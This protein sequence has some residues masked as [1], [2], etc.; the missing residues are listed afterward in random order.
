MAKSRKISTLL[1]CSALSFG[2]FASAA[3]ASTYM[4][5]QSTKVP[6]EVASTEVDFSKNDLIQ[7]F[8]DLFPNQFDFLSSNDFQM[9]GGHMYPDDEKIRYHLY[10][11]KAVNGKQL[12]GSVGFV[13]DDLEIEHFSFQPLNEADAL[14]PAKVSKEEA[15]KIAIE[16]MSHIPTEEAYQLETD[17]QQYYPHRILT[18]PI[19]Y[20]FMFTRTKHQVP[21]ADQKMQVTVLGNGDVVEFYK[22]PVHKGAATFEDVAKV[23]DE[24][25]ILQKIKDNLS[26]DLYYSINMDYQTGKRTIELVYQPRT[27]NVHALTGQWQRANSYS[28]EPPKKTKIEKIVAE[29]LPPKQEGITKE[30]ARKLAEQLL[31]SKSDDVKLTIQ[32]VEEMKNHNGQEVFSIHYMYQVANGGYGTT[33]EINKHTGEIIQYADMSYQML[34]QAGKEAPKGKPVSEKEAL[35]SAIQHLKEWAPSY[36]HHY[37][38]PLDEAHVDEQSGVYYFSFP[39]VVNGIPVIGDQIS[40][41]INPDSSLNSFYVQYQEEAQWPA[42]DEIISEEEA[43][44][45]YEKAL[46][47]QLNYTK[48]AEAQH[49]DLVYVPVFNGQSFSTLDAKTGKWNSLTGE[50]NTI[51]VTH[52]WAEKELNY[53]LNAKILDVKDGET[54]NGDALATKG[55]ALKVIVNSLTYFYAD[56]YGEREDRSQTFDNINPDHPYYQVVEHAVG[57]GVIKQDTSFDVDAPITREELA[58]WYIRILG[59]EQAAKHSDI[60]KLDLQDA[61]QVQAGNRG[62]VALANSIG[63]LPAEKGHF[64]P[65][66]EVTYAELAVSIIRLA[67]EMSER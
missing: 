64:N 63:L 26:V 54:F 60:Y 20:S 6:I 14:F 66:Q 58:V 27:S 49:Y 67:H 17:I 52:P 1:T 43:R 8:R 38:Y 47:A 30:E 24:K 59:L 34:E 7:K 16:F 65:D 12:H 25:E 4:D 50:E 45:I 3:Q 37:A 51:V 55:E 28:T 35:A 62:Y 41:S 40:V 39:R 53:L 61:D 48:K 56:W 31:E 11:S 44:A 57:M 23:K 46:S 10:F 36:L 13:G 9:S 5:E 15:R 18:E 33:L 42:A 19:R 32:S 29:P 2:L 22:N 21:I